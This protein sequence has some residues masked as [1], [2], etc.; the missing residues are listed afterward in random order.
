MTIANTMNTVLRGSVVMLFLAAGAMGDDWPCYQNDARRSGVTR[1]ALARDLKCAW[2]YESAARPRPA[3]PD[4]GRAADLLDFDHCY[5]PVASDGLVYFASSADDTLYCLNAAT[6]KTKWRFTTDAP[7]RFA[8][9]VADGRCYIAGDDGLVYCLDASTGREVWRFD[10]RPSRRMLPG[11]GRMISRW[12]CRSGVLVDKGM[13]Y[14]TCGIWP[15]EGV[16]FYAL[17]AKTGKLAWC[18]DTSSAM[19]M[20]FPHDGVSFGGPVPQGYLLADQGRLIVPTGQSSPAFFEADTGRFVAWNSRGAGST[21]MTIGDKRLIVS[22]RGWIGDQDVRL[23]EAPIWESDGLAFLDVK[24]GEPMRGQWREYNTLPTSPRAKLDRRM[25]GQIDPI[26]GRYRAVVDGNRSFFAGMG[27]VKRVEMTAKG[28]KCVWQIDHS[29]VYSMVLA[30]NALLLGSAGRVTAVST[31]DGSTLWSAGVD[32]QA[33]GI[34]VASGRVVVSTHAGTIYAFTAGATG[35]PVVH[36]A[37]RRKTPR[38]A[39]AFADNIVPRN[40]KGCALI[41]GESDLKRAIAL[42]DSSRLNIICLFET[43]DALGRARQM[44]L[45]L[46]LAARV[47]AHL[48]PDNAPLPYSD[49]FA[50]V[51][52]VGKGATS[53]A[54]SELYRVLS[55]R[56][57][58]ML[59]AGLAD[60]AL[61]AFLAKAQV[62]PAEVHNSG[63][64]TYVN[65][66]ALSGAFDWDSKGI[67]TD[68][69]VR[70]PLELLW[71]GAPGRAR[72]QARHRQY[73]HSGTPVAA[74]GRYTTWAERHVICVDAYNGTELWSH[75]I[76]GYHSV[77]GDN[78]FIYVEKAGRTLCFTANTGRLAKVYGSSATPFVRSLDKSAQFAAGRGGDHSGSITVR[79]DGA[80]LV[81]TLVTKTST[82]DPHD[83]WALHF[84][85]RPAK[86]RLLPA[87]RGAFPLI[88]DV[89]TARIRRFDGFDASIVVPQI[90]VRR[91]GPATIEVQIPLTQ[92][93]TLIAA[94]AKTFDMRARVSLFGRDRT[95]LKAL[96][97]TDGRDLMGNGTMTFALSGKTSDAMSP[98]S[99]IEF[100]PKSA[101][102]KLAASKGKVPA[103][104]RV[105]GNKGHKSLAASLKE[106]LGWRRNPLTQQL[107]ELSYVRGY[108]CSGVVSSATIDFFR[109]GTFGMYDVADD[110]GM[111]NFAGMKPGCRVSILPAMGVVIS[112]EAN[113]DCFCPY[114]LAASMALAPAR[115]RRN[116]DWALFYHPMAAGPIKQIAL[117]L[118]APGDRRDSRGRLWLGYPRGSAMLETGGCF[119][120]VGHAFG[121]PITVELFDDGGAVRVN[122]DRT[123]ITN[124]QTPWVSGSAIA[125]IKKLSMN[126]TYTEPRTTCLAI[127]ASEPITIDG[128][129]TEESWSTIPGLALKLSSRSPVSLGQAHT[130]FNEKELYFGYTQK[131]E[132][133]KRGKIAPWASSS[134]TNIWG[135]SHFDVVLRDANS[136]TFLHMGIGLGG[137]R[138]GVLKSFLAELPKID[139]I[140]ADGKD[141]EWSSGTSLVLP[142]NAGPIRLAW[143]ND[144]IAILSKLPKSF[145]PG[146][147]KH[148]ALRLQFFDVA[149][150][151]VAELVIDPKQGT[152]RLIKPKISKPQSRDFRDY[153]DES[154]LAGKVFVGKSE[155]NVLV[156]AVI[157][158]EVFGGKAIAK[159]FLGFALIAFDPTSNDHNIA[160]GKGARRSIFHEPTVMGVSFST[161]QFSRELKIYKPRREWYGTALTIAPTQRTVP[162]SQWHAAISPAPRALSAEIALPRALLKEA[163]ISEKSVMVKFMTRSRVPDDAY[164][165]VRDRNFRRAFLKPPSQGG[166]KRYRL[167]LH[168]AELADVKP[169]QRV[170]DISVQGKRVI[171]NFDIARES[172]GRY[173][174]VT[175]E[176]TPIQAEASIS[177]EFHPKTGKLPPIINGIEIRAVEN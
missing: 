87:A 128:K 159:R 39:W 156:E 108:G 7:L 157:P 54:P 82:P 170:F 69:R 85:F 118:G 17:H 148:T 124:T 66:A 111:R 11:N 15:S 29:R 99:H 19:Y 80:N 43:R 47:T 59:L 160:Q 14:V 25:R 46:G 114:S 139:A 115:T 122:T 96:P 145:S 143:T 63:G 27:K 93:E 174:A 77:A 31:Q 126:M 68:Q 51:V 163:G 123:E 83:A 155:D 16:Y 22:A 142:N 34:A 37:P 103:H 4:P 173:R 52:I 28:P 104:L 176:V 74:G 84:D 164:V 62:D 102:P 171:E 92:I 71:F 24:S 5:Y 120:P 154:P 50:S 98:L 18:N 153:E 169:G 175:R 6:G 79:K 131:A 58:K 86:A 3:W 147:P 81:V 130:R 57:G 117:N 133:D 70:W 140:K 53:V 88:I 125:G 72:M 151:G 162:E 127:P 32:G 146:D 10:G 177:V 90:D 40:A 165:A 21:W 109:S 113:A 136:P 101:A 75:E 152:A 129:L 166:P 61:A 167:L 23:G 116:E 137:H 89:N 141:T 35:R 56:T 168:F 110:S 138:Y 172:G 60:K 100:L 65:R 161:K 42:V 49:Y 119:G 8:P 30:S 158:F 91:K 38:P 26:G 33:R 150:A 144:G 48:A 134:K 36:A 132:I 121:L 41:V 64:L 105:D 1:E 107:E 20:A 135:G 12:P 94:P 73:S 112:S 55:P 13:V 67:T 44:L 106:E 149:S 9:H 95:Y 2:R 78:G 45:D 76:P 97:F